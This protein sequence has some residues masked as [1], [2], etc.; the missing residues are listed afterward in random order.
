M[1]LSSRIFGDNVMVAVATKQAENP[2]RTM[3]STLH[4]PVPDAVSDRVSRGRPPC[5]SP[6]SSTTGIPSDC[7]TNRNQI[8]R[9]QARNRF[10][11]F[12][13]LRSPG[14]CSATPRTPRL[15][16]AMWKYSRPDSCRTPRPDSWTC[17]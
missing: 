13:S 1:F 3:A 17:P 10:A 15:E 2:V 4:L 8:H 16:G 7:P 12:V 5:A 6:T 14:G 9:A 11:V